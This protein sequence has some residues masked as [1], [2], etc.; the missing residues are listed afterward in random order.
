MLRFAEDA[1]DAYLSK[2]V[3]LQA[4]DITRL[5]YPLERARAFERSV[6]SRRPGSVVLATLAKLTDAY[7]ALVAYLDSVR[8]RPPDEA[9]RQR[10]VVLTAN[11][12]EI[13]AELQRTLD[14]DRR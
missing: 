13:A 3:R 9:A 6:H 7:A 12:V 11:V 2:T 1:R 10:V 4:A 5:L 8:G 14:S